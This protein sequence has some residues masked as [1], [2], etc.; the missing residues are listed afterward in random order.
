MGPGSE[1]ACVCNESQQRKK[2]NWEDRFCSLEI[3]FSSLIGSAGGVCGRMTSLLLL[4]LLYLFVFLA[5]QC[6]LWDLGSLTMDQ[7][8][9]TRSGSMDR[10]LTTG[11]LGNSLFFSFFN[12]HS[13]FIH[14][15]SKL[16]T[17]QIAR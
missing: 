10:V 2:E 7:T 12:V 4:F 8:H 9:V 14:K 13:S 16:E 6:S 3:L 5:T 15:S 11:L 1:N 17:T